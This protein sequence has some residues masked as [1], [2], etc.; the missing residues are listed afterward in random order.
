[1]EDAQRLDRVRDALKIGDV[2]TA[3]QF[4]RIYTLSPVAVV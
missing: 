1:M 3:A 2:K 4:G